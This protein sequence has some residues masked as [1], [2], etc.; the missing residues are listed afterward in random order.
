MPERK[1]V[2]CAYYGHVAGLID[3]RYVGVGVCRHVAQVTVGVL[4][5]FAGPP[6]LFHLWPAVGVVSG[7]ML[8]TPRFFGYRVAWTVRL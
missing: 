8:E 6:L 2:L 3:T 5:A 4:S 7:V 1:A